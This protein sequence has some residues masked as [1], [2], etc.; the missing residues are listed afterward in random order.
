MVVVAVAPRRRVVGGDGEAARPRRVGRHVRDVF[1]PP[2]A[3]PLHLGEA[4]V[5]RVEVVALVEAD[6]T[7]GVAADPV[8]ARAGRRGLHD[9]VGRGGVAGEERREPVLEGFL[10]A[11]VRQDVLRERTAADPLVGGWRPPRGERVVDVL[12][13]VRRRHGLD[14]E[15]DA[16]AHR[17]EGAVGLLE[18]VE[19]GDGL[20]ERRVGQRV[21]R[22]HGPVLRLPRRHDVALAG[23]VRDE[24]A[25]GR[26]LRAGS[27]RAA[28]WASAAA[29]AG[30]FAPAATSA[31]ST[32]ASATTGRSAGTSA[33]ASVVGAS[34]ARTRTHVRRRR[35]EEREQHAP[36]T[37]GDADRRRTGTHGNPPRPMVPGALAETTPTRRDRARTRAAGASAG[38]RSARAAA[39]SPSPRGPRVPPPDARLPREARQGVVGLLAALAAHRVATGLAELL[40]SLAFRLPRDHVGLAGEERLLP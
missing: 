9:L 16:V 37:R 32:W 28:K 1:A 36:A 34:D 30:R 40:P 10:A 29:S 20:L 19:R 14:V 18:C 12:H 3:R 24:E 2:H 21:V 7:A 11:A 38:G 35:R 39:R 27:P 26:D 33:A 31:A 13:E 5:G 25:H 4:L 6:A 23:H 8:E 17:V 22:D 15:H